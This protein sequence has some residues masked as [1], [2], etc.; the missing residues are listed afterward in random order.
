MEN[1]QEEIK[2]NNTT[3][4]ENNKMENQ[5]ER[6]EE[7][8]YVPVNKKKLAKQLIMIATSVVGIS[9]IIRGTLSTIKSNSN[10]KIKAGILLASTV[11]VGTITCVVKKLVKIIK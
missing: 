2:E 3:I 7:D 9:F 11:T 10:K 6:I 5:Q 8:I 1:Q 4:K